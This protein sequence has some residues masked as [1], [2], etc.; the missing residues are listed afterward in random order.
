LTEPVR[1]HV[2]FPDPLCAL[3]AHALAEHIAEY[4]ELPLCDSRELLHTLEQLELTGRGGGHF[5]VARKWR[6]VRDAGGGGLV[7]A[8]GAEGEPGSRKDAALLRLRPHL[9]L[10]GLIQAARTV[11]AK[12]AVVW[13]HQG[14][15]RGVAAVAG[16]LNQ[17]RRAGLRDVRIRIEMGPDRYLTGESSSIV[18]YLSGGPALPQRRAVPA[19]VSGVNGVPTLVQNVETLAHVALAS[20]LGM[21]YEPGTLITIADGDIRTVVE[22]NGS[23]TLARLLAAR[24][25]PH[26]VLVGGIGGTW[27]AWKQVA[28]APLSAEAYAS[29]D[30]PLGAGV[31][32][33]LDSDR[34]G[35]TEAAAIARQLSAASA[36]Q[37][38]PCVFGLPAM[39]ATLFDLAEGRARRRHVARLAEHFGEI[40]GRG[41]CHHPDGAVRMIRSAL[42][43]FDDDVQAHLAGRCQNEPGGTRSRRR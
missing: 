13:L 39:S 25:D 18:R 43:V 33:L 11:G 8:N 31:L 38:G 42:R 21:D 29:T 30:V 41:G 15:H 7:I 16:A 35:L 40:E 9:V 4:G 23:T 32:H 1:F 26:A 24:P 17:R 34:C 22:V 14:D 27:A 36:R 10:D 37:C 12:D 20:R 3:H 2:G 6:A 28:E 19:A 5:P